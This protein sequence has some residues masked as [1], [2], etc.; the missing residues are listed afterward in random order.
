M[1]SEEMLDIAE[2]NLQAHIEIEKEE[3]EIQSHIKPLQ[4]WITR[5]EKEESPW[6]FTQPQKNTVFPVVCSC[7][8][9]FDLG[10]APLVMSI[11]YNL[12]IISTFVTFCTSLSK[13]LNRQLL[14][15]RSL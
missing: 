10:S 8:C 13:G 12:E 6:S 2:E 15:P 4:I 14:D 3:E 1:L 9:W 7:I 11:V 5:W